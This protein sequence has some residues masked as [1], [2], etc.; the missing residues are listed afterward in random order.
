MDAITLNG[1]LVWTITTLSIL[2]SFAIYGAESFITSPGSQYSR[3]SLADS[4][5]SGSSP[6]GDIHRWV[7][8]SLFGSS[9]SNE[10]GMDSDTISSS[11]SSSSSSSTTTS[12]WAVTDDWTRRSE[13]DAEEDS[14]I[15]VDVTYVSRVARELEAAN[16]QGGSN[17]QIMSE[18]DIWIDGVV[19]EIHNAFSTLDGQPLY[20]TA[21]DEPNEDSLKEA[22]S[23]DNMSHE[24]AMLVRCNEQPDSLL[25]SEGR[26]LP[27]LTDD[28]I[29]DVYQLVDVVDGSFQPTK[30]L[31]DAATN[32]FRQHAQPHPVD[33]VLS[34][35]AVGI[36]SWMT[37]ALRSEETKVS[38]FDKR[39]LKTL[40]DYSSYGS[41]RLV[42]G[43]F[44]MLYFFTIVGDVSSLNKLSP[45]RHLQL[46][47]PFIKAVWRDIREHGLSSPVEEE[48]L[49]LAAEIQSKNAAGASNQSN[50]GQRK[51]VDYP[52]MDECEILDWDFRGDVSES[53]STKT[54]GKKGRKRLSVRDSSS[55]KLVEMAHDQKT[56]LRIRDGEFGKAIT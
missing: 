56:P 32:M 49:I 36:A 1:N 44:Q 37:Q 13:A 7:S 23:N 28:E 24:I 20:D 47:K 8:T 21:I 26:A 3:I 5:R 50:A 16:L 2:L 9:H 53:S 17:R 18:E 4:S 14:S 27:P 45:A 11:T 35:D 34:L 6:Q 33:G 41:G 31:L 46:R 52:V 38:Q 15:V 25:I 12:S 48:R 42:E 54:I 19:D 43:D 22:Y 51:M 29:N 30:F 55:H 10:N 40:S 39:V